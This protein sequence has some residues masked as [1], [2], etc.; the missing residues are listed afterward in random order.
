M[1]LLYFISDEIDNEKIAV[2]T[3]VHETAY[4]IYYMSTIEKHGFVL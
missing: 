4:K 2:H 1:F 3:V